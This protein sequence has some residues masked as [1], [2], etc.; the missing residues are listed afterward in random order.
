MLAKWLSSS[1]VSDTERDTYCVIIL[2]G[3]NLSF[4]ILLNICMLPILL[5][6]RSLVNG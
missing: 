3:N 1:E 6:C 2:I 4:G 5:R